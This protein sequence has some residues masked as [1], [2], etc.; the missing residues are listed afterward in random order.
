MKAIIFDF[1][2]VIINSS[3]D[4]YASLSAKLLQYGLTLT[5]SDY[6]KHFGQSETQIINDLFPGKLT[7]EQITEINEWVYADAKRR[8]RRIKLIPGLMSSLMFAIENQ[9]KKYIVTGSKRE[10]VEAVLNNHHLMHYFEG[11]ITIDDVQNAKP[12]PESYQLAVQKFDLEKSETIV[13]EDSPAGVKSAV[14]AG[15][16]TIVFNIDNID[17]TKY[18]SQEFVYNHEELQKKLKSIISP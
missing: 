1:D 2:G 11:I 16:R 12:H 17:S 7:N 4:W 13:V 10:I 9:L 14:S 8:L 6:A 3:P 15:L 18:V 5:H